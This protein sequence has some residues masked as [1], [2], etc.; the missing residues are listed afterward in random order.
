MVITEIKKY[1]FKRKSLSFYLKIFIV[2]GCVLTF[3]YF[4]L[5]CG[6]SLPYQ[7]AT[8]VMINNQSVELERLGRLIKL[9]GFLTVFF[10]FWLVFEIY[11]NALSNK[12]KK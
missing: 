11:R 6:E 2:I 12:C 10:V 1:I 8:Q 7:D 9:Y 3:Y 5:Y 4:F